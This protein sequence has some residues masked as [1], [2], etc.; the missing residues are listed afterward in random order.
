[1]QVPVQSAF[2]NTTGQETGI[3]VNGIPAMINGNQ[4]AAGPVPLQ[5][6]ENL[7]TARAADSAGHTTEASVLVFADTTVPAISLSAM[8]QSGLAPFETTITI[9]GPAPLQTSGV[10]VDGPAQTGVT[11]I[12]T[13]TYTLGMGTPGLYTVHVSATDGENRTYAAETAVQVLDRGQV[14]GLLQGKWSSMKGEM[15]AGDI[16]A[17]LTYFSGASQDS[18]RE[19]FTALGPQ[20]PQVAEQMRPIQ[21]ITVE[22]GYAKYRIK[23][24]EIHQGQSYDISYWIYFESVGNGL[25]NIY[26]Y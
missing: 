9:T 24:S 21:L 5:Q 22:D 23:R 25:W 2:T 10:S 14:D 1:M 13:A 16:E 17:A 15:A 7:L 20:L 18:Y 12:D 3:T 6:G 26:R 19:I 11:Q 8:P 4:F